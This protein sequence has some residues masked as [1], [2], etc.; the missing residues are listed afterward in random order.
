MSRPDVVALPLGGAI[1]SLEVTRSDNRAA[2]VV[3]LSLV[4]LLEAAAA[5]QDAAWSEFIGEFS[6]LLLHVSSSLSSGR[7]ASM[8]AYAHVLERLREDDYRRLRKYAVH[9]QSKF[10]TWLVV[11]ARRLCV[12]HHR[13]RYGR[14]RTDDSSTARDHRALRRQIE[15]LVLADV[16]ASQ[17]ADVRG[18]PDADVRAAELSSAVEA[19]LDSLSP[20]DRLLLKLR[21]EDGLAASEIAAALRYPSP[22]HVYR[23]INALHASLRV[24]LAARGIE[25]A[26]P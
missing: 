11:V 15:D 3:P 7:D 26:A 12:D 16:D 5:E 2:V 23:R 24:A 21:H 17:V 8:D 1:G 13:L 4:R 25:S 9:P 10:T 19:V 18:G 14:P 6:R 20:A 22:F